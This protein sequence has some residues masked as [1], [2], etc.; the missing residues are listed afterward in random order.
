MFTINLLKWSSG[1]FIFSLV[2]I[3]ETYD[4]YHISSPLFSSPP[5]KGFHKHF[6]VFE[7]DYNALFLIVV[8]NP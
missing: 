4:E 8:S 2:E 7:C 1:V 5:I 3:E 6:I